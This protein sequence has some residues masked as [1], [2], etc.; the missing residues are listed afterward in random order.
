VIWTLHDEFGWYPKPAH[1]GDTPKTTTGGL[2]HYATMQDYFFH[3]FK[4]V[5]YPSKWGNTWGKLHSSIPTAVSI[6]KFDVD[7]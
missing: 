7:G 3:Q 1:R 6:L 2:N 4:V 5:S